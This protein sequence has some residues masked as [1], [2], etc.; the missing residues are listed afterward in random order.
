[1]N[2]NH[3][4][5]SYLQHALPHGRLPESLPGM[6]EVWLDRQREE[7]LERF[8]KTGLPGPNVEEWRTTNLHPVEK[9]IFD[10]TRNSAFDGKLPQLVA[11]P[12]LRIVFV[13]GHMREDLLQGQ[14]IPKG[15]HIS[16]LRARL[17]NKDKA[18]RYAFPERP[19]QDSWHDLNLALFADGLA[20]EVDAGVKLTA[21]I[22]I[23][24]TGRAH[25]HP[26]T[27]HLRHLIQV[28]E[29][30][31]LQLV[32]YDYTSGKNSGGFSTVHA[33]LLIEKN[34]R[35]SR[36]GARV[37][38]TADFT[39][40]HDQVSVQE[41]GRYRHLLLN[42]PGRIARQK[43]EILLE[44]TGANAEL[45]GVTFTGGMAHGDLLTDIRHNA[46]ATTSNQAFRTMAGGQSRAVFQGK[47]TVA[48]NAAKTDAN[49]SHHGILLSDTA[50][51][52]AKPGLEIYA[53]DVKCSHGASCGAVDEGALFYLQS[54]GIPKAEAEAMLFDAFTA[55]ILDKV[56]DENLRMSL[57]GILR[58]R[59]KEGA[60]C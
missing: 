21:P 13:D 44:E 53:D 33:T 7:A 58:A 14:K 36:I 29:G 11:Q 57:S 51:I 28:S 17:N 55:E 9:N 19:G 5:P 32:E 2:M 8:L 18:L 12:A 42:L 46:P 37:A 30:A 48:P 23:I 25:E 6:G 60:P 10:T 43:I 40:S 3:A 39:L 41:N 59:M 35:L 31:G 27:R 24:L 16:S 50:E 47:V 4:I 20:L 49:Q 22:E 52:D 54:R 1:M 38:D 45:A 34:A 56:E 15:V 26:T